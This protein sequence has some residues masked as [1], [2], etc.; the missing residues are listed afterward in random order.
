MDV[1]SLGYCET[2]FFDLLDP[3]ERIHTAVSVQVQIK[4][5]EG[6]FLSSKSHNSR[7]NQVSAETTTLDVHNLRL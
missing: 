1:E 4:S 7:W 6:A 2:W 3:H 5:F